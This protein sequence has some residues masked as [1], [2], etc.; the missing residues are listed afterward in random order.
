M[1]FHVIA[2][3]LSFS[4]LLRAYD[5]KYDDDDDD[6]DDDIYIIIIINESAMNT[7]GIHNAP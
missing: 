2:S 3:T 5:A 4:I 6:D 7:R 1:R